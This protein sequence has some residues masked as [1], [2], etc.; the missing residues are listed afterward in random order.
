VAVVRAPVT[1]NVSARHS[2]PSIGMMYRSA[3]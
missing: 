3:A 2:E 1:G